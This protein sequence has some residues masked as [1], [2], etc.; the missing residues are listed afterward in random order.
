MANPLSPIKALS[1]LYTDWYTGGKIRLGI[2]MPEIVS[3]NVQET[4]GKIPKKIKEQVLSLDLTRC[5]RITSLS[6]KKRSLLSGFNHLQRLTLRRLMSFSDLAGIETVGATLTSLDLSG[7]RRLLTLSA[8]KECDNL[9][10]LDASDCSC[11]ED[12]SA[13]RE[14][15][16]LTNDTFL[17]KNSLNIWPDKASLGLSDS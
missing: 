5:K 2:K 9:T 7:C 1:P 16:R 13:L 8:L 10:F 12:I 3:N 15:K 6:E 14:H 11:L 17:L 4:L